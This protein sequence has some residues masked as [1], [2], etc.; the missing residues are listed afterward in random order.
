MS[1]DIV[2]LNSLTFK[3]L[4]LNSVEK[5]PNNDA[6]GLVD[7]FMYSYK[8]VGDRVDLMSSYLIA[9]GIEK[10][11]RVALLG[12][13]HPH[14]GIAYFAI[15][16]MGAI[17]VPILPDFHTN[18]VHHVLHH[19]G[20]KAMFVSDKY[21]DM[22]YEDSNNSLESVILLNTL[23]VVDDLTKKNR[24][25]NLNILNRDDLAHSNEDDISTIIYTSGTTGHSKGVVL[26]N[27]NLVSNAINMQ[28]MFKV[29]S[30]DV[31]LSIL[32][33]AHVLEFTVGFL[34]PFLSGASIHYIEKPPTPRVLMGAFASVKPTFMASVPLVIEKIFKNKIYPNF[35]K[36]IVIQT[37]YKIPTIRKKLH[38]IAGKKLLATFGG[39]LR[40]F[41]IG[42][43]KLAVNVE[44]FL[45]EAN[46][47]FTI[48]YGLTETSPLLT[49]SDPSLRKRGSAGVALKGIEL[50]IDKRTNEILA[51]GPNIMQGYYNDKA[52]TDEVL[53][54]GWFNTEDLGYI[55][56]DGYL[57]INGRSKNVI[58]GS[59]GENIYPEQIES[60]INENKF[61]IE[62]IVYDNGG[63]LNAK[64]HF[65]YELIDE[66]YKSENIS[67]SKMQKNIEELLEKLRV[68]LNSKVSN[69]SR[70]I[71]FIEHQE[72]FVKTA[73]KKIKRYLYI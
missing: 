6:I 52:R 10:G 58:I 8:D 29:Q 16:Q 33:L 49:G 30:N 23:K 20:A 66:I 71:K 25:N 7:G 53:K 42:G 34:Y 70:V 44:Q 46:F 27:K 61:V 73:T 13:N 38:K 68:E 15:V 14:W 9:Q 21:I 2:E 4:I 28:Y 37:L 18:E 43:A 56:S 48:G 12:E 40:F 60:V 31:S 54:D 19:S 35:Q 72:P 39:R 55:D 65:N 57:F 11:D 59:N 63:Q 32:P 17:A 22:V 1:N 45:D 41:G 67:D 3:E 62:S 36:N 51:K 26:S 69:S 24:C 5:Y 50:K 64:I 47:P